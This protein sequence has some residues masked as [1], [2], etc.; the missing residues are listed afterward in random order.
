MWQGVICNS[1]GLCEAVTPRCNTKED[2]LQHLTKY[3]I[4]GEEYKL[5][6][7]YKVEDNG[8][9]Q[10]IADYRVDYNEIE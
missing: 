2:A 1:T 5:L 8:E 7:K 9:V 4:S 3:H 6:T 10:A